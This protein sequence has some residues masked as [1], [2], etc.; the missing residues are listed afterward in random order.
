MTA[1][2]QSYSAELAANGS[3]NE[4]QKNDAANPQ[5]RWEIG[6]EMRTDPIHRIRDNRED[7]DRN[8]ETKELVYHITSFA[9]L[10]RR[11]PAVLRWLR[12]QSSLGRYWRRRSIAV[13]L[14]ACQP[15]WCVSP[16]HQS[17]TMA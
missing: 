8:Q 6:E 17:E 7:Q 15:S 4:D 2:R 14:P 16:V 10:P 9:A 12:Y 11:S 5:C 1:K 13:W 3:Y